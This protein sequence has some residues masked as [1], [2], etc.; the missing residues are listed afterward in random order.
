MLRQI[1][2]TTYTHLSLLKNDSTDSIHHTPLS[3]APSPLYSCTPCSSPTR[4][5]N[6]NGSSVRSLPPPSSPLRFGG[7]E[8]RFDVV[9][10]GVPIYGC[11]CP[12]L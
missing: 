2:S 4:P 6:R 5:E 8:L 10:V 11:W 9:V 1:Q 7:S 3:P 12:D